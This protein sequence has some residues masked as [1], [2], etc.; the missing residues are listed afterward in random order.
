MENTIEF[1]FYLHD[2]KIFGDAIHN[3]LYIFDDTFYIDAFLQ[4]APV[5]SCGCRR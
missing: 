1:N 2:F 4:S 5:W 3:I